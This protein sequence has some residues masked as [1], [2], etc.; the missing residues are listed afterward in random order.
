M[1]TVIAKEMLRIVQ[2]RLNN[3]GALKPIEDKV[4]EICCGILNGYAIMERCDELMR[5]GEGDWWDDEE[6]EEW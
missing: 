5:Q 2:I 1:K 4:L 3:R 6:D